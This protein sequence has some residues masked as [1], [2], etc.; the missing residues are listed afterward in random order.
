MR[1]KIFVFILFWLAI[2]V[3]F[4][5]SAVEKRK[6]IFLVSPLFGSLNTDLQTLSE[7]GTLYGLN[8]LYA[9]PSLIIGSLGHY[10]KLNY[11]TENGYLIHMTYY[12]RDDKPVQPML[13]FSADYISIFTKLDG[14]A[15]APFNF[16]NADT[17][18]WAFHPFAGLSF[19]LGEQRLTPFVGYFKEQVTTALAS[20]GFSSAN[21]VE[22]NY[23]TAG[24]KLDLRFAHFIRFSTKFYWRYKNGEQPLLSARNQL[25][26][27]FSPQ[28]GISMKYDYFD[29]KYEKNTL[30]LIGPTFIF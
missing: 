2:G 25:D 8:M 24:A 19:K 16:L 3:F 20:S 18:V 9:S 6:T 29:D 26:L 4:G 23:I 28:A 1:K 12:F 17:S 27:L 5:V 10:S 14:A 7:S 30:A 11:S 13:S 22:L 15:A 21:F